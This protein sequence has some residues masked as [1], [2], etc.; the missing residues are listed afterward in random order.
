MFED[1][2][3]Y[4]LFFN[5]RNFLKQGIL[6][7]PRN[8]NIRAF[9]SDIYQSIIIVTKGAAVY[10]YMFWIRFDLDGIN[11]RTSTTFKLQIA[12]NYMFTLLQPQAFP[13]EFNPLAS[14]IN[15]LIRWHIQVRREMN[16]AWNF[17]HNP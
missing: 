3:Y 17:K 16:G 12:Y 4:S 2:N 14:A 9:P 7:S 5:E 10:P 6:I 8:S 11:I 15:G 13:G 1:I